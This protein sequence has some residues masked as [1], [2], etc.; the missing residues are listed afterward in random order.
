MNS[1]KSDLTTLGAHPRQVS[2]LAVGTLFSVVI[3]AAFLIAAL[4][5]ARNTGTISNDG[6]QY[7]IGARHLLEQ[8][9]YATNILY[10]DEHYLTGA[11]PAPQTVWPPGISTL[12]A[13]LSALG[14]HEEFA[15]RLI[16]L[17]S[18]V[19]VVAGTAFAVWLLC[20]S[21]SAV[22]AVSLWQLTIIK[23][24]PFAAA[25]NSDV[26]FAAVTIAALVIFYRHLK[27]K[28][29]SERD[30]VHMSFGTLASI[31]LLAGIAFLLRYAG[32]LLIA[33][34]M[35]LIG[36]E[37]FTRI[38][39]RTEAVVLLLGRSS[40]AA[41][42]AALAFGGLAL[43]N[44]LITGGIRGANNKF[45]ANSFLD[46]LMETARV[47]TIMITGVS[48][49]RFF[50]VSAVLGIVGGIAIICFFLISIVAFLVLLKSFAYRDSPAWKCQALAGTAALIAIYVGG[51]IY[52]GSQTPLGILDRYF[53][54]ILPICLILM[55]A[56]WP[57]SRRVLVAGISVIC[58]AQMVN[59][60]NLPANPSLR[61]STYLPLAE[62]I[63]SNTVPENVLLTVGDGQLVGYYSDRATLAI[64]ESLFT[65]IDWTETTIKETAQ[66]YGADFVIVSESDNASRYH[67]FVASLI[68]GNGASW[69]EYLETVDHFRIY[70]INL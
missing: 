42:P 20:G 9:I 21:L 54:P 41:F 23:F 7:V 36:I 22:A 15:G 38:R 34:A 24:W 27:Y 4:F 33:W 40:L 47:F 50:D 1:G 52:V 19:V 61:Y 68:E 51:L 66:H 39:A 31:S 18:Y 37:F 29:I 10:F 5:V 60:V 70:R 48:G 56:L 67:E 25:I 53:M 17:F 69:L 49:R 43:R 55:V 12:I 46:L 11:L 32:A 2:K 26:A 16:S 64:T 14:V 59:L 13:A 62:W 35:L 8:E 30:G 6:T 63:V 58:V 44:Y 57:F 3:V 65:N 28:T 45:E